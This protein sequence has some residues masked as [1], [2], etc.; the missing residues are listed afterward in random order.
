MKKIFLLV[1]VFVV[2][3]VFVFIG[4]FLECGGDIGLGLGDEVKGFVVDVMIG[5]VFLDKILENWVLVGQ[6]FIDGFEKV[7]FKVDVQYVLV[8]NIVVEQQNQIQVMVIGGVKV[9]IIGVKDGKQL[10]IQVEVVCDV[11]V[12]VIVY[13]C[14]IE[15]IDVVDYY[16]VF[17]NFEVGKFQGQVLFDGFVECVGYEVLYN[18]ELFLGLFDDVNLV[19]FFNG[20]MEVLQL[21]ID[22]G[23]L[24]VVFGQIEIFQMVIEGWKLENVQCC[25]DLIF[26]FSYGLEMFDGVLFLNDM[27]VCVII[28]LV[29]QVGKFVLV[30]IGQDFEVEFVKLIM[31]GVQYFMINKDIVLFVEQVIKMVGQFQKGE[32]VDVNDED[33]YDNGKK[34]VLVYLL[35]LVI[36]IKENV[37]EV[38]V[39]VLSFFEIVK[40]YQ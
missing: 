40:L 14:L 19:V 5:V 30:V 15:N 26:M 2:V 37:V 4:C 12:V 16:V 24:K 22:D 25:M 29:Q 3:G 21:K 31:E 8:S 20:V 17:D 36:V 32:E 38:Y 6:L 13:D 34:V 7:G 18:V 1:I 23:M 33:Q 28:I 9:I 27:F 35:F 39:N 11:G 10:I